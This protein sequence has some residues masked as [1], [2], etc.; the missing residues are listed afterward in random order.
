ML[1]SPL[2]YLSDLMTNKL[3]LS[4][5][6]FGLPSDPFGS[7]IISNVGMYNAEELYS[8]LFP[9]GRAGV[10][11]VVPTVERMPFVE[12]DDIVIKRGVRLCYTFEHRIT[13]GR[14]MIAYA[15]RVKHYLENVDE[16]V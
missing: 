6:S 15:N 11:I 12:G 8:P 13:D 16:I 14:Y 1:L 10:I 5:G 2:L 3:G 9:L 7:V 4:L